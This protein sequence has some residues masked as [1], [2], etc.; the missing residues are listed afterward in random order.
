MGDAAAGAARGRAMR[1]P[2]RP[3]H[4]FRDDRHRSHRPGCGGARPS[5]SPALRPRGPDSV[6]MEAV[7][8]EAASTRPPQGRL[9]PARRPAAVPGRTARGPRNRVRAPHMHL[10]EHREPHGAREIATCSSARAGATS[11]GRA[12]ASGSSG[13]P[14]TAG[15]RRLARGRPSGPGRHRAAVPG[16]PGPAVASCSTRRAVRA[17]D[18]TGH[19]PAGQRRRDRPVR[20]CGRALP[21]RRDGRSSPTTPAAAAARDRGSRPPRTPPWHHGCRC[22]Q[23]D[24]ARPASR[25]PDMDG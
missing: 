21:R 12:T 15:T 24:T 16:P 2:V 23:A 9:D 25:P 6:E 13:P 10:P 3:R 20:R 7:R 18:R 11:A 17:A 14:R 5:A 1:R 22:S 8:T 4:R 19:H